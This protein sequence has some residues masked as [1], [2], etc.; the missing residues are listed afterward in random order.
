MSSFFE[1]DYRLSP[2]WH[3]SEDL[4]LQS[5]P[6]SHT[7]GQA[8]PTTVVYPAPITVSEIGVRSVTPIPMSFDALSE[9]PNS[10]QRM[11]VFSGIFVRS[12]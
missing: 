7:H 3:T 1:S 11:D 12:L 8:E 9:E 4:S 6:A 10:T 5:E 2:T